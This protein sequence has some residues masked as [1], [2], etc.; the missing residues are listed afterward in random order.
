VIAILVVARGL[1]LCAA[2]EFVIGLAMEIAHAPL[3]ML[4]V[5]AIC[6]GLGGWFSYVGWVARSAQPARM[7]TRR[8]KA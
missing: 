5:V 6:L 7:E 4:L 8:A 1:S 3:F 2:P